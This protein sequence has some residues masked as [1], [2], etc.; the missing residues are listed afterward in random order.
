MKNPSL[1]YRG[2]ISRMVHLGGQWLAGSLAERC[3]AHQSSGFTYKRWSC[4][5]YRRGVEEPRAGYLRAEQAHLVVQCPCQPLRPLG[6]TRVAC[7]E[8]R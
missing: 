7:V 8:T 1:Y 4:V 6:L 3:D 2:P 5:A